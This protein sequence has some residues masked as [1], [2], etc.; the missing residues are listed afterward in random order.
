M[1]PARSIGYH[2]DRRQPASRVESSVPSDTERRTTRDRGAAAISLRFGSFRFAHRRSSVAAGGSTILALSVRVFIIRSRGAL[3]VSRTLVVV[4]V[5]RDRD[6]ESGTRRCCSVRPYQREGLSDEGE[7][8]TLS[9]LS[10]SLT[11]PRLCKSLSVADCCARPRVL[12]FLRPRKGTAGEQQRRGR[13]RTSRNVNDPSAGSPTE[14]LLRLL[15]PLNDQ[16]W[17]SSR[18]HRQCRRIAAHQSED[19]TKSFNR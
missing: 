12:L 14:T 13:S 15:L 5:S 7:N 6:P 10:P 16:V 3:R 17:S 19:L 4:T 8:T 9:L 18:Q 11:L 1:L 2:R